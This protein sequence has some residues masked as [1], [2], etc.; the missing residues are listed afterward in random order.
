MKAFF[1]HFAFEF[2][3]G[4][5]NKT[6]LV[7]NY[8]FPL[9]F[10]MMMGYVMPAI[11]PLYEEIMLPSL[12]TFAIVFSSILGIPDPLVNSRE[13]GIFRSYKIN[14]VPSFSILINPIISAIVHSMIVFCIMV[15]VNIFLFKAPVPE[16]WLLFISYVLVGIISTACLAVLIG[17]ISPSTQLTIFFSQILFIPSMLISGVMMPYSLLP[18]NIGKI[19]Q[20]FPTTHIMSLL[21]GSGMGRVSDIDPVGS[22]I[23]LV[24][25]AVLA[26][27]IA[28]LLFSWDSKNS[29]RKAHP[30]LAILA[31]APYIVFILFR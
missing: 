12:V 11:N 22:L 18:E 17:V 2:R 19:A 16:N 7:M 29:T 20:M 1:Q 13:K 30:A 9:G 8:I 21:S 27:I 28:I 25:G 23:V 26:F 31:F 24:S 4:I 3:T 5:R 14:G 15:T 10:F 6:L